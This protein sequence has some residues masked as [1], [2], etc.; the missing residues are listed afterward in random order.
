MFLLGDF[1]VEEEWI[2]LICEI[3]VVHFNI[4]YIWG[5]NN[6]KFRNIVFFCHSCSNLKWFMFKCHFCLLLYL[7]LPKIYIR[8]QLYIFSF[9]PNAFDSNCTYLVS[10]ETYLVSLLRYS[11]LVVCI[12]FHM[13]SFILYYK[14]ILLIF[15]FY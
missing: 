2:E 9:S 15:N 6:E 10:N 1:I 8:Y 12:W 4:Y 14:D 5:W 13:Y 7:K 11:I 3:C